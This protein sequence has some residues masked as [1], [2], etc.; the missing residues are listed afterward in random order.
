MEWISNKISAL[1]PRS[2]L[3]VVIIFL[4]VGNALIWIVEFIDALQRGW[5]LLGEFAFQPIA[6]PLFLVCGVFSVAIIGVVAVIEPKAKDWLNKKRQNGLTHEHQ[7]SPEEEFHAIHDTLKRHYSD[8]FGINILSAV[9]SPRYRID[10]NQIRT[11]LQRLDVPRIPVGIDHGVRQ[12]VILQLIEFSRRSD[13]TGARAF[14][15]EQ[16][17]ILQPAESA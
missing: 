8:G 16:S 15:K 2:V 9:I 6:L 17:A 10:S 1:V 3:T 5:S 7:A 14:M 11:T 12:H 13:L 4:L